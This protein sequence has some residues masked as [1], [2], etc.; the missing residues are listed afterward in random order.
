MDAPA[1]A[2][3]RRLPAPGAD[4]MRASRTHQGKPSRAIP[5]AIPMAILGTVLAAAFAFAP[6]AW[7]LAQDTMP[8]ETPAPSSQAQTNAR[9]SPA[10]PVNPAIQD[11]AIQDQ[12]I[13]DQSDQSA[14]SGQSDQ[15]A[16][17]AD[18]APETPKWPVNQHPA[19][20]TVTWDSHGLSVDAAN[21]SL[22]QILK[23]ISTATGAKV[24]GLTGDERVFGAY[25]PGQARD[26]L[27]QLLLG[28]GY[29]VMMIG[30]LGQGAPRQILLSVRRTTTDSPSANANGASNNNDDDSADSDADDQGPQPPPRPGFPGGFPRTPQQMMQE[31]Q[32]MMRQRQ[33]QLQQQQQNNPPPPTPPNQN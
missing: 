3:E 24:E 17:P 30:D 1:D 28:A 25:G 32:Q 29:N 19:Q 22:Q 12:A 8:P 18:P 15:S 27:S 7:P 20:A 4:P 31:R 21:S 23:D 14:Q 10:Q 13:Q 33:E 9:P 16:P 11:Q 26:V 2:A 6:S 5:S